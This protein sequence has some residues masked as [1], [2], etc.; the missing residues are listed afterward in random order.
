MHTSSAGALL[1]SGPCAH[2]LP[3]LLD[4]DCPATMSET[5]LEWKSQLCWWPQLPSLLCAVAG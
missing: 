2:M 3:T 5:I 4:A 1:H